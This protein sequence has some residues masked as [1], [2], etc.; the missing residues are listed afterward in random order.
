M[1][2]TYMPSPALPGLRPRRYR[3]H[4]T[5][6]TAG[7]QPARPR[8]PLRA[9]TF[10]HAGENAQQAGARTSAPTCGTIVPGF[11]GLPAAYPGY[12]CW[13]RKGMKRR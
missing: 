8:K 5:G 2:H 7:R 4:R 1:L 12:T 10:C 11:R 9:L 3:T 6:T 13:T